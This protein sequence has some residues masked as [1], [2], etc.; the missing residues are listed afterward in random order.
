[1]LVVILDRLLWYHTNGRALQRRLITSRATSQQKLLVRL[2]I[3]PII[4]AA[5][6][7]LIRHVGRHIGDRHDLCITTG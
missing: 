4:W 7:M 3:H 1:M 5:L 6:T 2:V